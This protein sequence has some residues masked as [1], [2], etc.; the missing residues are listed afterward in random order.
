MPTTLVTIQ[1]KWHIC[2]PVKM[3]VKVANRHKHSW[4]L[5]D[6]SCSFGT[7]N[8]WWVIEVLH[9]SEAKSTENSALPCRDQRWQYRKSLHSL[10]VELAAKASPEPNWNSWGRGCPF[11]AEQSFAQT[12]LSG[13]V[14][15][16]GDRRSE[17]TSILYLWPLPFHFPFWCWVVVKGFIRGWKLRI[18]KKLALL[19]ALPLQLVVLLTLEELHWW[20]HLPVIRSNWTNY[21]GSWKSIADTTPWCLTKQ[22]GTCSKWDYWFI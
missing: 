7:E 17:N 15:A 22:H 4:L 19:E 5:T 13:S 1:S 12:P 14:S 3:P 6:N 11:T 20:R 18:L 9:R 16:G 2:F 8:P 21:E 10:W